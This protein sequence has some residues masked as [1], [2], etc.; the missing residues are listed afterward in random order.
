MASP[1]KE[2]RTGVTGQGDTEPHG[3]SRGLS[4]DEMLRQA[5]ND[6]WRRAV[7]QA[8]SPLMPG[9]NPGGNCTPGAARETAPGAVSPAAGGIASP[10]AIRAT[11]PAATGT[12]ILA[13]TGAAAPAAGIVAGVA[14][15]VAVP[16]AATGVGPGAISGAGDRLSLEQG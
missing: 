16:S 10:T 2:R 3:S 6:H 4:T 12:V 11:S 15:G 9:A 8:H 14:V 13:A 7:E 1:C 5:Q